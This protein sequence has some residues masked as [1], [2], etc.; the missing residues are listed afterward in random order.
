MLKSSN[1]IKSC[2]IEIPVD[3]IE[4]IKTAK[5]GISNEGLIELS[6]SIKDMALFNQ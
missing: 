2:L 6:E 1:Q 5:K 3:L 4:P